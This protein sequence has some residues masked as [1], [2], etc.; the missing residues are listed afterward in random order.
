MRPCPTTEQLDRVVLVDP[1]G[2]ENRILS[3]G[4][5]ALK[6]AFVARVVLACE[7]VSLG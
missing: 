6:L 5:K 1:E 2:E 7:C 4:Q 3:A